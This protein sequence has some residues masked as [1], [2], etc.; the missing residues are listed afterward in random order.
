VSEIEKSRAHIRSLS[1]WTI[2]ALEGLREE[3]EIENADRQIKEKSPAA[4]L[5]S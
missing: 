3:I 4:N 2:L 5:N 1:F